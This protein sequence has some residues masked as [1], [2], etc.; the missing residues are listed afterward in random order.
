MKPSIMASVRYRTI[1]LI[2][3]PLLF[4]FHHDR[5]FLLDYGRVVAGYPAHQR[6][7][8]QHGSNC[9]GDE[10]RIASFAAGRLWQPAESTWAR[11]TSADGPS[12]PNVKPSGPQGGLDSE[13][14]NENPANSLLRY[15][16]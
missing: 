10:G 13:S 16:G 7:R 3:I 11:S 14:Q 1:R 15:V 6:Q 5:P 9:S 12:Y 2:Y 4:L 8:E